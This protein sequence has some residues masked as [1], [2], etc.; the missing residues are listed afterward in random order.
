M[1]KS[2]NEFASLGLNAWLV[3][4][5]NAMGKILQSCLNL[6]CFVVVV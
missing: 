5:C 3:R 4:Q 2:V 1:N 6:S